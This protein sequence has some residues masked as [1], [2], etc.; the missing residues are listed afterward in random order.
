MDPNTQRS[1][2]M[3]CDVC[4]NVVWFELQ[5]EDVRGTPHHKTRK[6]LEES[7][8][9]CI[10]CKMV[11]RSAISN[12]RDSRGTRHGRGYWRKS[13][14]VTYHDQASVRDVT[15]TQEMGSCRPEGTNYGTGTRRTVIFPIVG[16]DTQPKLLNCP[17]IA[18]TG[19][20]DAL[21]LKHLK[22]DNEPPSLDMLEIKGPSDDLPVWLYGN[23]WADSEP[24][25]QGD[26]SHLRLMGVGARF[27]RSQS[28]F[29]VFN[30]KPGCISL[31]GS[32][33]G[34]CTTEGECVS[35]SCL[36]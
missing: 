30:L 24:K 21:G 14:A 10:L 4:T 16:M 13:N 19:M 12:Y 34:I 9:T 23:W 33:I 7:A 11:L 36:V 31:R 5:P 8:K 25:K 35:S 6:A 22:Q 29:D 32:A 17:I 27:A 3:I 26:V 2:A 28:H 15:Y 20:L 1:L 18:P